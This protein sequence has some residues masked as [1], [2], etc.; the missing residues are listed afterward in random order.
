MCIGTDATEDAQMDYETTSYWRVARGSSEAGPV[1]QSTTTK[2][3]QHKYL[4][5]QFA[6]ALTAM[7]WYKVGERR[8]Y[9]NPYI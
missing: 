1:G 7:V 3:K 9:Y 5:W 8:S 2:L 4:S 6:Y